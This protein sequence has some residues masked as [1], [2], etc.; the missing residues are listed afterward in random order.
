MRIGFYI[1][2]FGFYFVVQFVSEC[3]FFALTLRVV[4][5]LSSKDVRVLVSVCHPDL[6]GC[7]TF[8]EHTCLRACVVVLAWP[9]SH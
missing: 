7:S 1:F 6:S 8:D 3:L 9:S 4:T 2:F 5:R